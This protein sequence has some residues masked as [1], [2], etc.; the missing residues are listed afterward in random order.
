VNF[1]PD[2]SALSGTVWATLIGAVVGSVTGGIINLLIQV[3]GIRIARRERLATKRQEDLAT[4]FSVMVKVIRMLSSIAQIR[5]EVSASQKRLEAKKEKNSELWK[6]MRPFGTMPSP[7]E[8]TNA[9]S[10]FILSMK[11][12]N[13]L[14]ISLE[15]ID[16]HNDFLKLVTAYSERRQSLTALLVPEEVN[17]QYVAGHLDHDEMTKLMPRIIELQTLTDAM[18]YR[19]KVDYDE[20][21]R[22]FNG[23]KTNS[24]KRFGKD[25]PVLEIDPEKFKPQ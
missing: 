7:V 24:L 12:H 11:D 25:F 18:I 2:L 19:S 10:A 1:L 16:V 6:V 8:F 17:G 23:L 3:N 4:A 22:V 20:A 9:E 13:L 15:L 5:V 14:L 21:E